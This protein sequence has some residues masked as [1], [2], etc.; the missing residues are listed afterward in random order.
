MS[1]WWAV[2]FGVVGLIIVTIIFLFLYDGFIQSSKV[3]TANYPFLGRF[4]FFFHEL[5]PFFRQYFGDDDAFAP[6]I[7]IDRIRNVASGSSGYFA[8]DKFDTSI[9]SG[10]EQ[11]QMIHGTAPR[12]DDE[13][14][15]VYPLIGE[16]RTYPMQ[17]QTY[18]YRSAMS[19]WSLG[20]EATSAMAKAC[21]LAGAAFNTWEGGLSVHHIP[22]VPFSYDKKFFRF[23]SLPKWTKIVYNLIP[24]IRLKNRWIERCGNYFSPELGDRDLFLFDTK[25]RLFYTIDRDAPLEVFPKPGELGPEYGQ[26]IWQIWSGLYG[27]RHGEYSSDNPLLDRD[28]FAKVASFVRAIEIKLAQG[29][30]QTG[31]ILKAN[32]NTSTIAKIRGVNSGVDL[33]SPNRFPFYEEGKEE[34]FF[35]FL[36][37]ISKRSWWKPVWVKIVVSDESNI[38]PLARELSRSPGVGPDFITVDGGDGW[39][40]A[41]P[42]ALGMLFGRK[43][44]ESLLIVD[45]VLKRFGVRDRVKVF[46]SSKLY[47]P[48]MSARSLALGADAVGNARSIMIAWWCIRAGLCS[49]EYGPCPI[50]MATMSKVKRRGYEQVWSEK[51]QQIK[52]YILAHNKGLIQVAAVAGL[53]S[54]HLLSKQHLILTASEKEIIA[55]FQ[56]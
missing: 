50:G 26:I 52:N 17:F 7:V 28:R 2:V 40:G 29:A 20:F 54:P 6:R 35:G 48:H 9:A 16:K 14:Q 5:R 53:T 51:V 22:H 8:F 45:G 13:M 3:I 1:I 24:W 21:V 42:I 11:R 34:A 19:L 55:S 37:E 25:Y 12:N 46:A 38:E 44:Y 56:H 31:G 47:A 41:A 49:G 43:I 32:K 15:P 23:K 33:H 36:E 39:S 4:R 30:K 10:R 27:L 18:F